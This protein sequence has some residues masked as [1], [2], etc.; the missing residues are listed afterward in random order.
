MRL[1]PD[2][3][4][5][6]AGPDDRGPASA[7]PDD[8][9]STHRRRLLG[10]WL[11]AGSAPATMIAASW[12]VIVRPGGTAPGG[13]MA[14]HAAAAA[15]LRTLPWWDW[16]GWSEWFYGGQAIG[17]NYPPLGH[18]WMRFTHPVHGQMAAVA[19]GL[20]VL[21]PW[22]ALR[23]A[24]AVGY[25]ERGQR[26]AVAA[27]LV[28]TAAAAQ[29]H[30]VLSGFHLAQTHFG[31]WPAMIAAV[32]GLFAAAWAARCRAPLA[33][34]AV[35]GIAVLF[36]PTVVPGI[37]AVCAL[38]LATSGASSRQALRWVLTASFATLAVAAWWLV[39]FLAGAARLVPYRVPLAVAWRSGGMWQL[40]ML[41]GLGMS[42]CWA[43]S[44]VEGARRLAV[45]AGAALAATAVAAM[46][47]Y[48]R[49][50]RWIAPAVVVAALSAAGLFAASGGGTSRRPP[51]PSMTV[52]GAV[53]LLILAIV[54]GRAELLA[55]VALLLMW[56]SRRTWV[57]GGVLA[58]FAVLMWVP[59]WAMVWGPLDSPDAFAGVSKSEPGTVARAV[60]EVSGPAARGLLYVDGRYNTA[61]GAVAQC[62][63]VRPW[64]STEATGGRIRTTDGLYRE[65]SASA[66]FIDAA[67]SL[68]KG[69]FRGPQ[70]TRPHW[71]QAWPAGGEQSLDSAATAEALGARWYGECDS[72]GDFTIFEG[73]GTMAE[74]VTVL[75]YDDEDS[76]HR[77]AVEWWV[78]VAAGKH[79]LGSGGTANLPVL[80]HDV[81]VGSVGRSDQP[82]QGVVLETSQD[83]LTVTAESA[84]WAW[85]RVPWDPDWRAVDG[86]GA[87]LKGGP[88]H[89]VVWIREG[90]TELRWD[91]TGTVDATA[92]AVTGASL[93][94]TAAMANINRRRGWNIDP[95][96]PRPAVESLN[97]CADATDK[98][99]RCAGRTLSR[100]VRGV[101]PEH[102]GAAERRPEP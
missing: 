83:R 41:T 58:W 70:P 55:L 25:S 88:G 16:R 94:L 3:P 42:A 9:A 76:W 21:L 77:A 33:C 89:L 67:T 66:E 6:A 17:V 62:Q 91:V 64:R 27:A 38:L 78:A 1:L 92:A 80:W 37:A 102:K 45:A 84:G 71:E 101:R 56:P 35:V 49:P 5:P 34:G 39:P 47:G 22:G 15:W 86:S 79:P 31:S 29:M 4:P 8:G 85:L 75:A 97:R 13:D 51:R 53:S 82:A 90:V 30:W 48:L 65:T 19:L 54:T 20:L 63:W 98:W 73:P 99:L 81:A 23:L 69:T 100:L 36:N 68:H 61:S 87:V 95:D 28:L 50:E 72:G 74:G 59:L 18:A 52:L 7:E 46:L 93:L 60:R 57:W 43:A 96:R 10:V 44:R 24:R 11:A 40:L 12:W 32:L 14:G 2:D 26:A